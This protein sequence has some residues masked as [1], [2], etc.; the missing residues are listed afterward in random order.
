MSGFDAQYYHMIMWC[1]G[2]RYAIRSM[3]SGMEE[4]YG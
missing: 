2:T 1:E 3:K 4:S